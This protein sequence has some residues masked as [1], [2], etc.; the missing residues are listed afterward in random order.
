MFKFKTLSLLASGILGIATVHAHNDKHYQHPR[1]DAHAPIGV[2]GDHR[3][4]AGE[5]ML[6]YRYMWMDMEGSRSGSQ[7]ISDSDALQDFMVT[8][9]EMTMEMHMLGAMYA[10]SND[11]TLM[12]MVPYIT[13]K[14]DHITRMGGEFTTEASGI[15]DVVLSALI[16]FRSN[17]MHQTHFNLSVSVPTGSI[18]ERDQTPMGNTVLPF[19]MQIGSGTYD[20]NLGFTHNAYVENWSWGEQFIYTISTGENDRN[21]RFG[22]ELKASAWAARK[23]ND[24]IS[25]SIRLA[26]K[27]WDDVEADNAAMMVPVPTARADLRAGE[28]LDLGLGLNLLTGHKFRLAAEALLP[29]YQDLDGPQLETDLTITLGVQKAW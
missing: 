27:N 18:D 17:D 23:W 11:V 14:M 25:S 7:S 13:K 1:P 3:H 28:R 22:N 12:L 20:L 24:F 26:Y 10:P 19:P 29:V 15:G 8:P 9:T 5:F 21:Y 2:M 16:D 4:K 6:S